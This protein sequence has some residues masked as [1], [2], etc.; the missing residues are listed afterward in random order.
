L[1]TFRHGVHNDA[2][3]LRLLALLFCLTAWA[4]F[5]QLVP[6]AV[7]STTAAADV[8]SNTEAG[9]RHGAGNGHSDGRWEAGYRAC[10]SVTESLWRSSA[11]HAD[12]AA[13]RSSGGLIE[14][15]TATPRHRLAPDRSAHLLHI[16]LLI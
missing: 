11:I 4:A 5:A 2:V 6:P 13:E 14:T 10:V 16:P 3:R 7:D 9:T 15:R 12:L 8:S 1:T